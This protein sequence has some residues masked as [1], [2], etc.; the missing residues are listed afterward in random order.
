MHN[1]AILVMFVLAA[2]AE[3]KRASTTASLGQ[4][5]LEKELAS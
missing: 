1:F 3:R 4:A 2:C 5:A